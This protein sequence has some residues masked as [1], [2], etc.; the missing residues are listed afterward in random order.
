MSIA[1]IPCRWLIHIGVFNVVLILLLGPFAQQSV[2]LESRQANSDSDSARMR[3]TLTYAAP[4]QYDL[5]SYIEGGD[6][7]EVKESY[8]SL[9]PSMKGE[10]SQ[11]L[12]GPAADLSD[13]RADCTTSNCTFAQYNSLAVCSS[14]EDV[15]SHIVQHCHTMEPRNDRTFETCSQSVDF[16]QQHPA[17][18]PGN[19]SDDDVMVGASAFERSGIRSEDNS[20]FAHTQC[21]E[22]N[23]SITPNDD[24]WYQLPAASSLGEF[25]A[26]YLPLSS[27]HGQPSVRG[28]GRDPV[29]RALKGSIKLCVL[30]LNT[31]VE[32]G[33]TKTII[34]SIH[35]DLPWQFER[36]PSDYPQ[37]RDRPKP[38]DIVKRVF[39][40]VPDALGNQEN[41]EMDGDTRQSF[42][43][44]F[45][46]EVFL[47]KW[48]VSS[49]KGSQTYRS[50]FAKTFWEC[51]YETGKAQNWE[52]R[53]TEK[54]DKM[55]SNLATRLTNA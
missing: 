55:L 3:R 27:E 14:T 16:L 42:A 9:P 21:K 6:E 33:R 25:Y 12:Y 4:M 41:F 11:G 54:V 30:T 17:F 47:G 40:S 36:V 18:L 26:I 10:I 34:S 8:Y 37:Y 20:V 46:R 52:F 19:Y 50:D 38:R 35:D 24:R 23:R 7:A 22:S 31:T 49:Q 51:I 15:T 1:E 32:A 43:N 5:S 53:G 13:V 39:V 28:Q 2:S 44:Y 29:L 48:H 45:A